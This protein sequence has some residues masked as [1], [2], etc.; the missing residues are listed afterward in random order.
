MLSEANRN[1]VELG[2]AKSRKAGSFKE[3]RQKSGYSEKS[4]RVQDSHVNCFK[5]WCIKENMSTRDITYNQALKFIDNERDRGIRRQSIIREI[6]SIRIYFDYLL[7]SGII[8]QNIIKRIRIRQSGKKVLPEILSIAQLE[9]IYQDF[10]NLPAW[11]HGT[12][13]AK[14]LHQR[15]IV[16]LGLM[17]YQ[18]LDSGEI[19]RLET[20]HLN[21]SE[22]KI[23]IPSGRKSNSRSLR[24]QAAQ[25]LPLKTYLEETRPALL[26]KREFQSTYL[27]PSKKSSD[28]VCKIV[29]AIKKIHPKIKD[30]RQLRSS[31]LMNW[32]KTNNIR[33]VQYMAGHKSIRS[34]EAY[35]RED[36]TDLTKQLELFHPLR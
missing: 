14:L 22:G 32:L 23:Y 29:E 11:N 17:I 34:T 2:G 7:E 27:F 1:E 12:A 25:I 4:I 9:K 15:N 31:V 21:L 3:Y 16:I 28:L 8:H 10:L 35:R 20:G 36:L 19:S 26:E 33:Q 24:L 6:N 13:V 30:S 5:T 18:G